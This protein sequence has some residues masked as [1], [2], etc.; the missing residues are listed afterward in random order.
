MSKKI[1]AGN[2]GKMKAKAASLTSGKVPATRNANGSIKT[3]AERNAEREAA[4]AKRMEK[5]L[6]AKAGAPKADKP[7]NGKHAETMQQV[8]AVPPT[9]VEKT[10]IAAVTPPAS[11]PVKVEAE[12]LPP[13]TFVDLPTNLIA[14]ALAIAPKGDVRYYL[15]GVHIHQVDDKQLRIVATDGHRMFVSHVDPLCKLDWAADGVTIPRDELERV[16]KYIGKAEALRVEFGKGHPAMKLTEIAGMGEFRVKPIDG[17]F[18]DYQRVVDAAADVFGAEREAI[19]VTQIDSKYLKSAGVI[20]ATLESKGIIPFLAAPGSRGASVFAFS[21][22]PNALLYIMGQ[23]GRAE[24]LPAPTLKLFGEE[25]M[26]AALVKIEEQ[27]EVSERNAKTTKHEH[28]RVA[29]VQKVERLKLRR[30]QL[31]ANLA[32]KLPAPETGV[33]PVVETAGAPASTAAVH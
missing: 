13:A 2:A 33:S 3:P 9:A 30:D 18:P 10:V 16:V 29:S 20:A 23:E 8:A 7:G 5:N 22:T 12:P 14:A 4:S 27:I 21:E 24:A 26:R 19:A 32:P 25:A 1:T 17:K 28:F 15:N 31:R 11:E 6:A